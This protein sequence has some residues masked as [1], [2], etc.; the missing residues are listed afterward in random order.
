MTPTR[1]KIHSMMRAAKQHDDGGCASVAA[2]VALAVLASA[3]S[4]SNV[5]M[6]EAVFSFKAAPP[7]AGPSKAKAPKPKPVGALDVREGQAESGLM[8]GEGLVG[9]AEVVKGGMFH[10]T[11][12][13]GERF[14]KAPLPAAT[15]I[16][17]LIG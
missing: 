15:I 2:L 5:P 14:A 7:K 16:A 1:R 17:V 9:Q 8:L 3:A 12:G 4:A 10:G 13:D 6:D 11:G